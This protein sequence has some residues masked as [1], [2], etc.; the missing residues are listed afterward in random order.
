M[1]DGGEC[2]KGG[3][4]VLDGGECAKGGRFVLDVCI[5]SVGFYTPRY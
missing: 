2:A 5:N 4:L 3:R 1:L